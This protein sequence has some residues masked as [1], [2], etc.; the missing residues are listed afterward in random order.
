LA[1]V[2]CALVWILR[3]NRTARRNHSRERT[4]EIGYYKN[5][6]GTHAMMKRLMEGE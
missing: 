4:S 6:L 5:K 1:V 2:A 3:Q